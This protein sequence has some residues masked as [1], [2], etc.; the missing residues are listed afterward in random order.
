[1][2]QVVVSE[3]QR[4]QHTKPNKNTNRKK[5]Q[6][7]FYFI[8]INQHIAHTTNN[9][10]QK[11]IQEKTMLPGMLPFPITAYEKFPYYP[12]VIGQPHCNKKNGHLIAFCLP[13]VTKMRL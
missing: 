6:P 11:K 12:F 7:V 1:L 2:G 9:H 5:P 4:C 3:V 8:L 10:P 13:W